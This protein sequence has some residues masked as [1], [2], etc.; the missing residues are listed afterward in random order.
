MERPPSL[1][2]TILKRELLTG[3][4]SWKSFVLLLALLAVLYGTTFFAMDAAA[5]NYTFM[6]SVMQMLFFTQALAAGAIVFAVIPALA[7]VSI[8][9][10]RQEENYDL[11]LTTLITPRRIILGKFAAVLIRALLIATAALP[12]TGLVYF[13]AGVDV[14]SFFAV[15]AFLIPAALCNAAVGLWCS[16]LI[17]RPARAIFLTFGIIALVAG[18]VPV[19]ASL[20]YNVFIL[21]HAEPFVTIAALISRHPVAASILYQ[22]TVGGLFL[23]DALFDLRRVLNPFRVLARAKNAM[24]AR[25]TAETPRGP[26]VPM[27][28]IPDRANPFGYKD[29]CGSA[30]RFTPAA[31]AAFILTA[32]AYLL[33][34]AWILWEEAELLFVVG[35]LERVALVLLVPPM[36]AVL[37]VKE[38]DEITF[39]MLRMSLLGPGDLVAGK[40][41]A[42]LRLMTPVLLAMA[43]CKTLVVITVLFLEFPAYSAPD[44]IYVLDWLL[45]PLHFMFATLA[46]LLG[47]AL[48]KKLIPAIGGATG[49]TLFVTFILLYA[50]ISILS[51]ASPSEV[52]LVVTFLITHLLFLGFGY[53]VFLGIT[54][55][56]VSSQWNTVET[57]P[58]AIPVTPPLEPVQP[59][60]LPK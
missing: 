41:A 29:L 18:L 22:L 50:Q 8:N 2:L 49:T 26:R 55:T 7:A 24:R 48:P 52:E 3:L 10:E 54:I 53:M 12:F 38:R 23:F 46:A 58:Y 28:T 5:E 33:L 32:T 15:L 42:L 11:L 14:D 30:L 9:G 31:V 21:R 51:N 60:S 47:A 13:Y 35:I 20:Y 19:S 36:V 40:I 27:V 25:I 45:L 6:S 39:D 57:S 17:L 59:P 16:N 4:R 1:T 44:Y 37:M 34:V 56:I 43:L